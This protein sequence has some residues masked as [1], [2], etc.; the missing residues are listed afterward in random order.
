MNL[1]DFEKTLRGAHYYSAWTSTKKLHTDHLGDIPVTLGLFEQDAGPDEAMVQ[2][3]ADIAAYIQA[4]S[5]H[6]L[7]LVYAHY[8][9]AQAE[10]FLEFW[11]VPADVPRS[12]ITSY[13]KG[14][15]IRVWRLYGAAHPFGMTLT[16]SPAWDVEHGLS[17]DFVDGAFV[18]AN[19]DEELFAWLS[20][21]A[22]ALRAA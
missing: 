8:L 14:I 20:A 22:E 10:G 12:R 21:R 3:A 7:D 11:H 1:E 4:H 18:S 15:E 5:A 9:F 17:F 16:L 6:I 19:D 13:I 2:A